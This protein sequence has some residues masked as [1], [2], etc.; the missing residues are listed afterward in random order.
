VLVGD[1]TPLIDVPGQDPVQRRRAGQRAGAI[2]VS[3][4][5][6]QAAEPEHQGVNISDHVLHVILTERHQPKTGICD[7]PGR[8]HRAAR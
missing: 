3:V 5:C 6:V 4:R 1:E 7:L 8:N 2:Q